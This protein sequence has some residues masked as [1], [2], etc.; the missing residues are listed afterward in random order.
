MKN[1]KLMK[2][3]Y[4]GVEGKNYVPFITQGDRKGGSSIIIIAS[5]L[6]SVLFA[7]STAY[8]GMKSGLTVAAGI[9]GS[10]LGSAIVSAFAKEKGIF[11]KNL[12]Q[13]ASS[14]GESV[15][16]GMIFVMPAI[17]LIGA[18]LSFIEGAIVGIAGVLIGIGVSSLVHDYLIVEQHGVLPYPESMAIAETLVASEGDKESIKYMGI[19]FGISGILTLLSS[20]F[21]N[22]MNNI[23]SY[24]NEVGYKYKMQTEVNPML[25][26]LGYIV[27]TDTSLIMFAGSI[28]SNFVFLPLIGYIA[29]F[30]NDTATVWNNPEVTLNALSTAVIQDAYLKYI[31]AG[32]MLAGGL[33][34]AV[35]LIPVMVRSIRNTLSK[36]GSSEKGGGSFGTI[37]LAAALIMTAV[38]A[39]FASQGNLKMALII[40]ALSLLFAMMFVIVAGNLTGTI[41]TSNLPV[42][43][44]TIATLV[45]ITIVFSLNGWVTPEDNKA[46]LLFATFVVTAIAMGG[47]YAQSQ[48]VSFVLG[49]DRNEMTKYL[50][51]SSIV[52]V[53]AVVGVIVILSSKLVVTGPG[54]EFAL[55]QANLM[56]TLTSGIMSGNLPLE[57]IIAGVIMGIF[58]YLLKLPVMTVAIGFYLPIATTSI[59][60]IGG[61]IRL[62]TSKTA[63]SDR[64]R[65]VKASNGTSLSAGLVAGS[66]IIG[67]IGIILQVF[68]I[69]TPGTPDGFFASNTMAWILLGILLLAV[70]IV[71][72]NAGAKNAE[73]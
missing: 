29:S 55:P 67:L 64:D 45:I 15:A 17:L 11:G 36:S 51:L 72:K 27:G 4:G 71:L 34:G 50:T 49:G 63:K 47:G 38:M 44:M 43:G 53:A 57:M 22:T 2:E 8:S 65:E 31:G 68:G 16:S 41:G 13:G 40:G 52:G 58:F 60:L 73:D 46:L 66:S 26:G 12:L 39:F 7:A 1:T 70:M 14:G 69:V 25:L 59:I 30:A 3:A 21:F 54:A 56:A 6:L 62:I 20:S 42:S 32:M 9:P 48:K 35:K 19:G 24:V 37:I 33:I 5:I 61:I 23:I 10:I 28:L 18:Q